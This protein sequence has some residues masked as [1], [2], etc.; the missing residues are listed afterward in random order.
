MERFDLDTWNNLGNVLLRRGSISE[1][2]LKRLVA[3]KKRREDELIGQLAVELRFC[4]SD[5]IEDA[6]AEQGLYKVPP[7]APSL[8][9]AQT[10]VQVALQKMEAA[11]DG[12]TKRRTTSTLIRLDIS[13]A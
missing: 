11:T 7:P 9:A 13:P 2:Q 5:E 4:T 6:L 12:L 10:S 1:G 3:E 8:K